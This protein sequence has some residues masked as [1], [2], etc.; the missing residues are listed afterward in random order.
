MHDVLHGLAVVF[1]AMAG[2]D[3]DALA[4]KV[5]AVQLRNIEPEILIYRVAH[6]IDRRV[7]GNEH[8]THDYL[9][10]EVLCIRLRG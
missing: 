5:E 6:R 3:N 2:H 1:P 9:A 8:V 7:A 10:P 4:R